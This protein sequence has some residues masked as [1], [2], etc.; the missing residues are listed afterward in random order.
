MLTINMVH[1]LLDGPFMS[2]RPNE[3]TLLRSR[4]HFQPLDPLRKGVYKFVIDLFLHKYSIGSHACLT[5]ISEFCKYASFD[6]SLD[7][8]VVEDDEWTVPAQFQGQLPQSM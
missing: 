3:Y 8:S 2:Q 4:P 6:S 5:R 1:G 7:L